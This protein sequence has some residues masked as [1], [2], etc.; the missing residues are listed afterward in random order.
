[1]VMVRVVGAV[2]MFFN[3]GGG[4]S[5]MSSVVRGEGVGTRSVQRVP[6][7]FHYKGG[8]GHNHAILHQ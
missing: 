5:R 8:N 7:S 3:R 6:P 2:A 1:M 4:R